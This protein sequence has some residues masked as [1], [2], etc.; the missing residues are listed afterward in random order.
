MNLLLR[1]SCTATVQYNYFAFKSVWCQQVKISISWGIKAGLG[2]CSSVFRANRSFFVQKWA[3]EQ[4]AE[5]NERFT[6]S[7]IFGERPERFAHDRSFP[8]SDLS[9]LLM[10]AHFWWATWA[11]CSHCSFDLSKMSDSRTS[12]INKKK[13]NRI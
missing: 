10:V 6:H 2:I 4:F 13:F 8:L 12:L 11:I 7:L 5:K 3:N 1:I 9:K